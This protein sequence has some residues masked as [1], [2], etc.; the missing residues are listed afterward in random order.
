MAG[1]RGKT[2]AGRSASV[3]VKFAHA[4]DVQYCVEGM[5]TMS[6]ILRTADHQKTESRMIDAA[7]GV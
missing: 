4:M 2:P 3:R 1:G 5:R 6:S 7:Y